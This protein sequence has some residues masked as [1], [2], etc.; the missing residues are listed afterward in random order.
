MNTDQIKELLRHFEEVSL[1]DKGAASRFVSMLKNTAPTFHHALVVNDAEIKRE[2]AVTLPSLDK[3]TAA[4]LTLYDNWQHTGGRQPVR[5]KGEKNDRMLRFKAQ[6]EVWTTPGG[7]K[8][9]TSNRAVKVTFDLLDQP[10]RVAKIAKYSDPHK[11][12]GGFVVI[13]GKRK[14]PEWDRFADAIL[15]A[16]TDAL[17]GPA[18]VS[19]N[20]T[21]YVLDTAA[22]IAT[23]DANERPD[24]MAILVTLPGG[25]HITFHSFEKAYAGGAP[26][27][28][29]IA[30]ISRLAHPTDHAGWRTGVMSCP[31]DHKEITPDDCPY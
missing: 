11:A 23:T 19:K 26:F 21:T 28:G 9:D 31:T 20:G 5:R 29:N 24:D 30:A 7:V 10:A 18:Y 17:C 25:Q 13:D 27:G 16:R 1:T 3:I 12:K 14:S 6:L 22:M 4:Q 8:I 2:A 15:S